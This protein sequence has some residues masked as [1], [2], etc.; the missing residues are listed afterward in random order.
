[1]KEAVQLRSRIRSL[2]ARQALERH[3]AATRAYAQNR[4]TPMSL[5]ATSYFSS[6]SQQDEDDRTAFG[7]A[8]GTKIDS[9]MDE[10]IEATMKDTFAGHVSADCG[11]IVQQT[12]EKQGESLQ[13]SICNVKHNEFADQRHLV[14]VR[15]TSGKGNGIFTLHDIGRGTRVLAEE[16]ILEA[17][18]NPTASDILIAFRTLPPAQI[19]AFL[20]VHG[21]A[22]I[23]F[24]R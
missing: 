6:S 8:I 5:G 18:K 2:H 12:P 15:E 16:R 21:H 23:Q 3:K 9:V 1:M 4:I 13:K 20:E 7:T 14:E 17:D 10:N 22:S 19:K 11:D 24:K